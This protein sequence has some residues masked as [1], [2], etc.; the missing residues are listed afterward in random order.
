MQLRT[1][2]DTYPGT[3][4]WERD[5]RTVAL[6]Q[7]AMSE[8]AEENLE[9]A[10]RAVRTAA[11][12]GAQIV[13]LPELFRTP[14]FPVVPDCGRDYTEPLEGQL[15]DSLAAAA[16]EC[17]VVLVAGSV[18][19]R[20]A[21]GQRFNTALVFDRD[22][23]L[24]P[25]YRKI[26]IPH[27]PSFF[28]RD[29][30]AEGDLGFQLYETAFGRLSVL[31]CYDQWF[32]EAARSAALMGAELIFYPTAI[33]VVDSIGQPEGSW[34]EAWETVQRGHA[35]A[36][37]VVVAAINRVGR[38]GDSKFWGGSFVAD[39]FGRVLL[40]GTDEEEILVTKIDLGHSRFARNGWRL[41]ESRRPECYGRLTEPLK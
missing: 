3:V 12:A 32:P 15:I 23:R 19:E 21:E 38:E 40:R 13:A 28:E 34:Q 27:D 24:L 11:G 30:F 17:G 6:V 9:T 20:S 4:P 36:N 41:R 37:N 31:I 35:V 16:K 25:I 2:T 1:I 29:Y 8:S 39:G 7:C 22:G 18:Y 5:E 14:Y 33:A 26:H 10:L